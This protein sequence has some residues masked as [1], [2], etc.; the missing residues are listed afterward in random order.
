[1]HNE[2]PLNRRPDYLNNRDFYLANRKLVKLLVET[3]ANKGAALNLQSDWNYL[4]AVARHDQ[5]E[6]ISTTN[7]KHIARWMAEDKH[8]ELDPHAHETRYNYADVASL[9]EPLGLAP[10]KTVGGFL[11]SPPDNPQGWEQ[12]QKGING[13][14][15]PNYFWKADILWGAA[16][17]LHQ[18]KDDTSSGIWRPQDRNRFYEH[19]PNQR[20]LY[21]GNCN[22][23]QTGILNLL[24]E[25]KSGRAP[26]EGFY[27]GA[28]VLA[29]DFLTEQ[30][31]NELGQFIDSLAP[32][33]TN[34]IVKWATL[35]QIAETW[36]KQGEKPFRYE[37]VAKSREPELSSSVRP[38]NFEGKWRIAFASNLESTRGGCH[39]DEFSGCDLY[40][41]TYDAETNKVSDL[42]RLTKTPDEGEWFPSLSPDGCWAAY[43]RIVSRG[44][45]RVETSAE[46]V[47][48]PTK[49]ITRLASPAHFPDWSP[50]GKK[51]AYAASGRL[52]QH[53][54]VVDVETDCA[55]GRLNLGQPRQ[56]T[57]DT[58]VVARTGDPDF[59]PDGQH[60]AFN[61]D[62]GETVP[63]QAAIV[64]LGGTELTLLTNKDGSE[65]VFVLGNGNAVGFSSSQ[66]Q[67][68]FA[69]TRSESS[70]SKTKSLLSPPADSIYRSFDARYSN[71]TLINMSY[72]AWLG[73]SGKQVVYGGQC[74]RGPRTQFSRLI[75]A[76]LSENERAAEIVDMSSAIEILV[77]KTGR[78]F[79]TLDSIALP[80]GEDQ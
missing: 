74:Y 31:I 39:K 69:V 80:Y 42:T 78:D 77:K 24:G 62:D 73:A 71:C 40:L 19:D 51:I 8:V 48:I 54:Y 56:V 5:N 34:G 17:G 60:L 58:K 4:Q 76:R 79:I 33:L 44:E 63:A 61:I 66:R 13:K 26:R 65:H 14:I 59:L 53:I 23:G 49:Q 70:W 20:L 15:F 22:A 55:T 47:H 68:L 6:I 75:A 50:D 38:T 41:A 30:S 52:P 10:T 12:H 9:Y 72:A 32:D 11:F 25:I 37:C 45:Q 36:K 27:T 28:I 7:N 35:S 1:V 21:I 29:Q 64:G 2:E 43:T 46:I 16:T 67:G 57:K 18:G 3:I